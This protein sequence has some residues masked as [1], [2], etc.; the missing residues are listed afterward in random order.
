MKQSLPIPSS[1]QALATTNLLSDS[2]DLPVLDISYTW[3]PTLCGPLCL[4][5]FTELGVFEVH[6]CGSMY[7]GLIPFHG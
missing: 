4:A 2:M 1:P 5:C 3:N 6:P 7:Q